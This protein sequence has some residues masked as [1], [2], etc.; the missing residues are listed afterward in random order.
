MNTLEQ[1]LEKINHGF[2]LRKYKYQEEWW[3][4]LELSAGGG[5]Y[6]SKTIL[7]AIESCH[8][9]QL[10]QPGYSDIFPDKDFLGV[11]SNGNHTT[12]NNMDQ[13]I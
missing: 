11:R 12:N 8:K 3:Y 9:N 6:E 2:I 4:C 13:N 1:M 10:D 5:A 7:G